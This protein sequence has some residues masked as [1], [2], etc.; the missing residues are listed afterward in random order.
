MALGGCSFPILQAKLPAFGWYYSHQKALRFV[1][2]KPLKPGSL[3][4]IARKEGVE[5]L[6]LF[7]R[8]RTA[9]R[10]RS[11]LLPAVTANSACAAPRPCRCHGGMKDHTH[12]HIHAGRLLSLI[13]H[14]MHSDGGSRGGIFTHQRAGVPLQK[15]ST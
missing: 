15:C 1:K 10:G 6:E 14:V 12:S 11:E 8:H 7:C 13:S 3:K 5:P 2:P 4:A 9:Q